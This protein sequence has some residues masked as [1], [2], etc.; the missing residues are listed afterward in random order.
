MPD[1][2]VADDAPTSP[3]PD[4]FEKWVLPFLGETALWPVLVA[5]IGH[6]VALQTLI[7]LTAWRQPLPLGAFGAGLLLVIS[8]RLAWTELSFY[9]RPGPMTWFILLC[10]ALSIV[11]AA[12]SG[13]YGLL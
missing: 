12:V 3:W 13:H 6:I 9:E 2:Q 8:G 5:V 11:G 10:W 1:L 4:W 7:L